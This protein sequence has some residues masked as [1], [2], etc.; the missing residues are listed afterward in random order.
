MTILAALLATNVFAMTP[1]VVSN[2]AN[3]IY[4]VE[5]GANARVPYGVL[6]VRVSGADEAR[7]VCENTVRNSY[8]RWVKAGRHEVFL[9][10][11]ADR[12][13]PPA[14]DAA[15]NARWKTNMRK[16]ILK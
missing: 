6:S 5:G 15:G 7:R 10:F 8:T 16:L 13:C 11:L 4:T 14:A 1:A 2:T 9:D 12:Y 3:A